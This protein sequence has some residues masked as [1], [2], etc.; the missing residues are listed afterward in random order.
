MMSN[1]IED[2]I[3]R[4]SVNTVDERLRKL[5]SGMD[6]VRY[7]KTSVGGNKMKVRKQSAN[8]LQQLQSERER[9]KQP[10]F[11]ICFD[12]D[13]VLARGTIPIPVAPRAFQKLVDQRGRLRVPVAYVTNS[14]NRNIDRAE[15][16]SGMLGVRVSPQMMIQAPGPLEI[17]D[18]LHSKF[19]LI[20]GQGKIRDIATDLGF[21]NVCTIEDVAEAYPLLDMVDHDNRRRVAVHGYVEKDF[22]RIEVIILLGEPKRWESSLQLLVDILT[23]DG[24]PNHPLDT[25]SE[26]HIPVIACNMD[27]QFQDRAAIPRYGHGAFLVC[28]EALY[29]KVSGYELQ[30]TALIGKP[31]EITY[32]FAEHVL[33]RE[34]RKLGYTEP[35]KTMY[36]VGDTPEVDIVGCNLYQRYVDRLKKRRMSSAL[37]EG[38]VRDSRLIELYDDQLPA[39]RNVPFSAKFF[40]QTVDNVEGLLVCT[41]VYKK[42]SKLEVRGNEKNFHGHRDFPNSSELQK[43]SETFDDVDA[44]IDYI[45]E[46]ETEGL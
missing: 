29:R 17:F 2:R 44:A 18:E 12:V 33:T 30:Y 25:I 9:H 14:L 1:K 13:G 32:R 37:V 34:S 45:L 8:R 22:P 19:C 31:S 7:R 11:G 35:L 6:D 27:L 46:K 26:K 41:G 23:S 10:R 5:S 15:Q 43:P 40:P 4:L 3:R 38:E 42:G 24:K 36:L 28:L 20:V 16:L 39:S 21:K